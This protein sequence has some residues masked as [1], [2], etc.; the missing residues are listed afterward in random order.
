M[1][2]ADVQ[3][4]EPGAL[5]E[6]FELDA[7]GLGAGFIRFHG[8]TQMTGIWWQGVE[9]SPWPIEATGFSATT[10]KPPVP[11]LRVGNINA[12]ITAILQIT[13]DLIGAKLT[14]HLTLGKYLD[15]ANFG[16]INPTA[17]P[18]EH[19]PPE[20]WFV[21]RKSGES[22]DVVEL[23]LTSALDF[24]GVQLPR[25]QIIANQCPWAY[26]SAECGYVGGPVANTKDQPTSDS[27]QDRC[28]KR[29]T[30]CKLRFGE[31]GELPFGGFPAASLMRM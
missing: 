21:E 27:A 6:L 2:S 15:A 7:S 8:Y 12:A 10:D 17:N 25:R 1:I 4:L 26:R 31:D 18:D 14:R 22:K 16:G 29:L 13:D 3:S 9:Y 28:G 19:F 24:Q 5:I 11:T 23:E 30:S 20:V